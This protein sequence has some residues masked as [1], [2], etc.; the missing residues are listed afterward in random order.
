METTSCDRA[1]ALGRAAGRGLRDDLAG[2]D[3]GAGLLGELR[4][5]PGRRIAPCASSTDCPVTD[6]T[7]TAGGPE[8]STTVTEWPRST[9]PPGAGS[10]R[11]TR[12]A[13]TVS[14]GSWSNRPVRSTPSSRA[15]AWARVSWFSDGTAANRP[16]PNHQAAVP[17]ESAASSTTASA[18]QLQVR[19]RRRSA[20][21]PLPSAG[22]TRLAPR[23]GRPGGCT[24]WAYAGS[25]V[26]ARGPATPA[27]SARCA[28]RR[29]GRDGRRLDPG[30]AGDL[31]GRHP[32]QPEV[33]AGHGQLGQEHAG[34]G[35][36]A[37]RLPPGRPQHQLV[38]RRR[39]P[40][41]PGGR[42]RHVVVHVP[43]GDRE[44]R[45]AP[46]RRACR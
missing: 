44:G 28:A 34:V 18:T 38:Q 11:T 15:S 6:G 14:L 45:L 43:V 32:A 8:E 7:G 30:R 21:Q 42:R 35:G 12:P 23:R 19:R 4:L 22:P 36:P 33:G 5:Q 24:G 41:H 46:V 17:T 10:D 27:R 37:A 1:A 26:V 3:V 25:A 2:L 39:D 29:P 16:L 31:P 13:A 20:G 40:G 9:R